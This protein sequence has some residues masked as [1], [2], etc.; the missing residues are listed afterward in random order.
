MPWGGPVHRGSWSNSRGSFFRARGWERL[1]EFLNGAR[2]QQSCKLFAA[3][4]QQVARAFCGCWQEVK[5]RN[6]QLVPAFCGR[7]LS[8]PSSSAFL[9]IYCHKIISSLYCTYIVLA[10]LYIG[11]VL[12]TH[13]EVQKGSRFLWVLCV[14]GLISLARSQQVLNFCV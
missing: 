10:R 2:A 1:Q 5:H 6:V 12:Q 13:A 3:C 8:V 9:H 4:Q 7:A 11:P 14:E